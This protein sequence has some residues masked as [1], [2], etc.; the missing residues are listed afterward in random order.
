VPAVLTI[1]PGGKAAH[2]YQV[3]LLLEFVEEYSLDMDA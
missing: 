1:N 2:L 3:L